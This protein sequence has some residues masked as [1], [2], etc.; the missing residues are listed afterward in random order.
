M[1]TSSSSF[2][3]SLVLVAVVLIAGAL[4]LATPGKVSAA[5]CTTTGN[6]TWD[7]TT[8]TIWDCASVPAAT[9]DVI[10]NHIITF[11]DSTGASVKT[12]TI[13]SGKTLSIGT[14]SGAARTITIYTKLELAGG[15][16]NNISSGNTI[17]IGGQFI[18]SGTFTPFNS[19]VKFFGPT[20]ISGTSESSFFH[21]WIESGTLTGPDANINI[22]GNF[23][24]NSAVF[25]PGS[26]TVT[27]NGASTQTITGSTTFNNISISASASLT[28]ASGTDISLSGSWTQSGAFSANNG[29][30][31]FIGSGNPSI[32]GSPTFYNLTVD[33][34]TTLGTNSLITVT[35]N[36]ELI[37]GTISIYTGSSFKNI[38]LT[39]GIFNPSSTGSNIHV[40]GNWS[41]ALDATFTPNFGVIEFN[42]AGGQT[43]SGTTTFDNLKII[44]G[45]DVTPNAP[46][47][48]NQTLS[49]PGSL[50]PV[51]GSNFYDVNIEDGGT[52]QPSLGAVINVSGN[53]SHNLGGNFF[54][55]TSTIVFD[56]TSVQF[57]DGD[58]VTDSVFYKLSINNTSGV[59][60]D[61]S[62]T[63]SN[64]LILNTGRLILGINNLTMYASATVSGTPTA[65]NMVVVD[66]S[67]SLCKYYNTSNRSFT[68]PI[69]DETGAADYSPVTLNFTS[70]TFTSG[71]AC[72]NLT[73]SRHTSLPA[74]IT[75][76]INRYWTISQTGISSFSC[77]ATFTYTNGDIVGTESLMRGLHWS[78]AWTVLPPVN[79]STNTISATLTSFSDITAG[80]S[81]PTAV[82]IEYFHSQNVPDGVLLT[83]KTVSEE[84]TLGFNLLRKEISD[85]EFERVN[86]PLIPSAGLKDG[87]TYSFL[88]EDA[89]PGMVYIYQL[90]V[91]ETSLQASTTIQLTHW[92][93]SMYISLVNR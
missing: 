4:F 24:N 89:E 64:Q 70:G 84:D 3:R 62:V 19:T 45:T 74:S 60:L 32:S 8:T 79:A 9:D 14:L 48:V 35:N 22:A 63:V 55:G 68:Y 42:G 67:G 80:N 49:L 87:S 37:K 23:T 39:G 77:N 56:G 59:Y 13:N 93:Y 44:N 78:G 33:K 41:K 83:W 29:L 26:G 86:S 28:A 81:I 66:S 10:I 43:I 82:N 91:I 73:N 12:I 47:T 21:L 25:I 72:V 61:R 76:Y 71:K 2:T 7:D 69:G 6:G 1:N 20:S 51:T 15:T 16:L 88:D 27:F 11:N 53:F 57:I 52:F 5:T 54:P 18:N 92:P 31:E 38:T 90:E 58:S 36:F 85:D 30:V 34:T 65:T 50:F 17:E 46:I 75:S 40:S